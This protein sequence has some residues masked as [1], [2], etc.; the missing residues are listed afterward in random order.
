MIN[1]RLLFD[2][3]ALLVGGVHSRNSR[4]F[5]KN[6]TQL[7]L[8]VF[9]F[10]LLMIHLFHRNSLEMIKG[11]PRRTSWLCYCGLLS[12]S[13]SSGHHLLLSWICG[14]VTPQSSSS[15]IRMSGTHTEEK[16]LRFVLQTGVRVAM[17]E[18]PES[19]MYKNEHRQRQHYKINFHW[20]ARLINDRVW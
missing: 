6:S 9:S 10:A 14:V 20:Q 4:R 7:S 16:R 19:I 1:R 12:S 17:E 11:R 8:E 2:D 15:V 18:N 3:N 5:L 13:T